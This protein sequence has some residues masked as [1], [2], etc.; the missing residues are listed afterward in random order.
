MKQTCA[1]FPSL[2]LQAGQQVLYP[3][4]ESHPQHELFK[5]LSNKGGYGAG[6]LL[7]LDL[8]TT[9][10]ANALMEALQNDH[11]FGLMAVSLGCVTA[12][13]PPVPSLCCTVL[14]NRRD[15]GLLEPCYEHSNRSKQQC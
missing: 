8:G 5:R 13:S 15:K 3:A 10:R 7:T 2:R 9:A 6:G 1:S 12:L 14:S 11:G 4:L